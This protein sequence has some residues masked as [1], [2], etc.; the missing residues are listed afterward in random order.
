MQAGGAA[1]SP[2]GLSTSAI[3]R[4]AA[5]WSAGSGHDP[6]GAVVRADT[7][8][9]YALRE[10]TIGATTM[11]RLERVVSLR[12]IDTHWRDHLG[13]M[14]AL[15]DG[16]GL[17]ALGGRSPLAEYQREGEMLLRR[18]RWSVRTDTVR[19]LFGI[20]LPAPDGQA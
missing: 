1:P 13:E 3:A 8:R 16:I 9:A 5:A 4:A 6:V 18:M 17:R 7:A 20:K 10:A 12:A 2:T 19:S 15:G 14:E 11:R